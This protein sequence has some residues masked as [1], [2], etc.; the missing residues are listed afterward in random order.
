LKAF[1]VWGFPQLGLLKMREQVASSTSAHSTVVVPH[2]S[3]W[4]FSESFVGF[5]SILLLTLKMSEQ[6]ATSIVVQCRTA[7]VPVAQNLGVALPVGQNHTWGLL[8]F[9]RGRG[10][11]VAC[12]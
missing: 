2:S 8:V 9:L 11:E 10:A 3:S 6:V 5:S 1:K 7:L 4:G 12:P